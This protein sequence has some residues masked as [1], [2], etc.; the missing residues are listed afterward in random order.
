MNEAQ[1]PLILVIDDTPDNIIL[2]SELLG[3]SYRVKVANNGERGLRVAAS[4][5][6]PDLILLDIMMPGLDG[7]EVCRRLKSDPA[8]RAIPVILLTAKADVEDESQGLELGAMDYINKPFNPPV[9][10][11]RVR[12]YVLLKQLQDT[13]GAPGG[14]RH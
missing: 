3:S 6:K 10:L 11:A 7:Y 1:K 12:N 9:L 5:P 2:M 4:A 13:L 8:T 14:S